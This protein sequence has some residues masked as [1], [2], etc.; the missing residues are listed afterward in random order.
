L[1]GRLKLWGL[2]IKLIAAILTLTW[3]GPAFAEPSSLLKN[4]NVITYYVFVNSSEG[5]KVDQ[6]NLE[7][8]LRFLANSSKIKFIAASE[9][10][11]EMPTLFI[12]VTTASTTGN[13]RACASYMEVHLLA[14]IHDTTLKANNADVSGANVLLWE[15][16]YVWV[17]PPSSVSASTIAKCE[18]YFKQFVNDWSASQ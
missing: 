8:S 18:Q 5:C 4:M 17:G 14:P 1:V 3:A 9:I 6:G 15:A 10:S 16:G 2:M 12:Q 11:T 7:T 13:V